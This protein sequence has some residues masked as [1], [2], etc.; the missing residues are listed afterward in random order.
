MADQIAGHEMK[1]QDMIEI[2]RRQDRKMQDV[3]IRDL[4]TM[5]LYFAHK[6]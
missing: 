1:M 6:L 4:W 5:L 2:A 3:T